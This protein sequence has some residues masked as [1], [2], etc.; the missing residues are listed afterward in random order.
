MPAKGGVERGQNMKSDGV[1]EG[2][3]SRE[4]V[5]RKGIQAG[6]SGKGEMEISKDGSSKHIFYLAQI[7]NTY[8]KKY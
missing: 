5:K 7:G 4:E 6:V 2:K 3:I 1:E 8:T